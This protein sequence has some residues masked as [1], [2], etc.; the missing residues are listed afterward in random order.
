[1][2]RL[3][4]VSAQ[5]IKYYNVHHQSKNYVISDLMLLLI[6]NLKQKRLSKQLLHKFF[7]PFRMKN[8][9]NKQTFCLT[10][11]N[12]YYIHNIFHVSFLK[13]YLHR[14]DDQETKVMM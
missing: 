2:Q 8:E 1:M 3:Q 5:Q 4:K 14:V 11:F 10:L 6:R 7:D 12:I 9:I 13:S